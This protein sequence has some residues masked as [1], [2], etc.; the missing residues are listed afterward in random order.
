M[1]DVGYARGFSLPGSYTGSAKPRAYRGWYSE[2]CPVHG[3]TA[4][5]VPNFHQPRLAT[6][7]D[8]AA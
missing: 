4:R 6:K 1:A 2:I 7:Y 5:R 8:P 3:P